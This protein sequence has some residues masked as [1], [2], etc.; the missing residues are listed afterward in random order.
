M[1]LP[2]RESDEVSIARLD[3]R[4]KASGLAHAE[5]VRAL[6][7][8]FDR[9]E[10]LTSDGHK[11]ACLDIKAIQA[12]VSR[13]SAR[14]DDLMRDIVWVRRIAGFCTAL[15]VLLIGPLISWA[16]SIWHGTTDKR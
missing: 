9:L 11:E 8:C 16:V 4:L 5:Q 12:E 15:S 7:L 13:N 2:P 14:I 10:K 3:E 1:A 6:L